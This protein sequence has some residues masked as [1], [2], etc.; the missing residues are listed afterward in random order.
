MFGFQKIILA[1]CMSGAS[2]FEDQKEL[3][4][5][6]QKHK[7]CCVLYFYVMIVRMKTMSCTVME[8]IS[9]IVEKIHETSIMDNF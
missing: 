1:N 3:F 7:G 6:W 4:E 8:C 5:Y 2:N 9:I